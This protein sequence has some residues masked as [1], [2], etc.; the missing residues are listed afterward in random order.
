MLRGPELLGHTA[1]VHALD[2]SPDD[3]FLLSASGD[4]T[5]GGFTPSLLAPRP[6]K[7][8]FFLP[9]LL[10]LLLLLLLLPSVCG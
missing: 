5:V 3:K 10:L 8:K 6:E 2:W 1:A 9:V 4:G 7:R